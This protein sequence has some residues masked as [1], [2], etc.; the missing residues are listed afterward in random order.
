MGISSVDLEEDRRS[1]GGKSDL[2]HH[3]HSFIT[4]R[5]IWIHHT[6]IW[7]PP[8]D[9][10]ETEHSIRVQVEAAGMDNADFAVVL[11]GRMLRISGNRTDHS[12][13]RIYHQLEI[14]TGEFLTEVELPVK[15]DAGNI[16]AH[17]HDG[18][19]VVDLRKGHSPSEDA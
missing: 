4:S 17:Y 12:E 9:V 15:V 1:S 2:L 13:R 8:T 14:H 18:F 6:H 10:Y 3:R 5:Y 7:R 11:D 16:R 19:L